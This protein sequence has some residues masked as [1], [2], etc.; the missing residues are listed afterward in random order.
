MTDRNLQLTKMLH[1]LVVFFLSFLS[2]V[3][4]VALPLEIEIVSLHED[5]L[6]ACSLGLS[7]ASQQYFSLRTNQQPAS[8]TFLS[9]Q[10][11]QP[12]R[13]SVCPVPVVWAVCADQ[14]PI[15]EVLLG[16]RS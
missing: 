2:I 14:K 5:Q 10:T 16:C 12:N 9:E 13:L 6:T 3:I 15:N 7:A 1:F 8:S 11:S 4:V